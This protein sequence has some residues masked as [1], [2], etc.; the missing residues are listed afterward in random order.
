MLETAPRIVRFRGLLLILTARELKARYRGSL[1]GFFWSL[2]N[3]LLLLG[4]YS[5]VFAVAFVP[6]RN[7]AVEPYA[8]FLL[9]GLFPWIWAS[10]SLLE[11]VVSL[12]ANSGLIRKAVFPAELLPVVAVLANGAHFLLALP[13]L[14]GALA[15]GRGLGYPVGGFSAGLFPVVVLL[16]LPLLCGLALAVAALNAHFRDVRDILGNLLTLLFFLTPILYPLEALPHGWIRRAIAANPFTP[17]TLAY[18]HLLF[19]GEVPGP[20]LWL[21]MAAYS[22]AAWALGSILF[23]RLRDTLVEA[24]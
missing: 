14:G 7:A 12:Q 17:F 10:G 20:L 3:P 4:V 15:V 1:L 23:E 11:G 22:A 6:Q 18:Q 2:A 5:F 21:Q 9:T 8:L 13:I 24:V 16:E 19:L